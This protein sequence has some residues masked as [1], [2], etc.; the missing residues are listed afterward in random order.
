MAYKDPV[1]GAEQMFKFIMDYLEKQ[2]SQEKKMEISWRENELAQFNA[3][4]AT[5]RNIFVGREQYCHQIDEHI[6]M[7][8][9][10]ILLCIS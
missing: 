5:L 7:G 1:S 9:L 4:S 10:F 2:L 3:F 6:R 8:N